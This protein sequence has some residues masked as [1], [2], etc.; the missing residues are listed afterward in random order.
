MILKDNNFASIIKAVKEGRGVYDN[1][2]KFIYYLLSC[3]LGELLTVFIAV[4][5]GFPLILLPVQI[6]WI[7]LVTDGLPALALGVEPA[8]S[9]IM[10]K[11]PRKKN[12]NIINKKLGMSMLL[13]GILM[14]AGTLFLFGLYNSYYGIKYAQT[15]AFSSLVMFQMFNALNSRTNKSLF[16]ISFFSNKNLLYAI[17]I[18]IILQ[19]LVVYLWNGFFNVVS[20]NVIDWL[21]IILVSSSILFFVEIRKYFASKRIETN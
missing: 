9:D 7:N 8:E 13:T 19:L 18:S 14:T 4:I 2:K 20:L 1:I 6:L 11:R 5:L 21:Y 17:S 12:A 10:L 16:S 3:N 15:M